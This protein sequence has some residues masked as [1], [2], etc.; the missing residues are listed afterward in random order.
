[1]AFRLGLQRLVPGK[2]WRN[3]NRRPAACLRPDLSGQGGE[4]GKN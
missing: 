3:K 1:M 4:K 2:T